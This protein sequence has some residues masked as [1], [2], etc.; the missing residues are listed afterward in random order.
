MQRVKGMNP[1]GT[2]AVE[3]VAVLRVERSF[4]LLPLDALPQLP[5]SAPAETETEVTNE[6]PLQ[7]TDPVTEGPAGP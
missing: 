7:E 1:A 5:V 6:L 4:P 2:L 3:F